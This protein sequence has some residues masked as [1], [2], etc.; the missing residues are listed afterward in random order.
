MSLFSRSIAQDI[1]YL[2]AAAGPIVSWYDNPLGRSYIPL[3]ET[4]VSLM[5]DCHI[6]K[7]VT[8]TK[9]MVA[10]GKQRFEE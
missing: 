2:V 6:E 3:T 7:S 8:L 4:D 10:V 9:Q 5:A 1:Y